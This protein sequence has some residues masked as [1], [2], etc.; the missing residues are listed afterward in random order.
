MQHGGKG[1]NNNSGGIGGSSRRVAAADTADTG[2]PSVEYYDTTWPMT[3]PDIFGQHHQ[4]HTSHLAQWVQDRQKAFHDFQSNSLIQPP[5]SL[6]SRDFSRDWTP[7]PTSRIVPPPSLLTATSQ[8]RDSERQHPNLE[9]TY[10]SSY[11]KNRNHNNML[12]N[13][14]PLNPKA[15]VSYDEGQ[16]T[17]EIPLHEY[18]VSSMYQLITTTFYKLLPLH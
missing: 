1:N 12:T 11:P 13:A 2:D 7:P 5:T 4:P 15:K 16:F 6:F 8:P 18:T 17:V 3:H 9:L 10:N 14:E